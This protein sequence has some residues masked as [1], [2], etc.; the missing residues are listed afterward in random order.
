MIASFRVGRVSVFFAAFAAALSS[1]SALAQS[2][3]IPGI[4]PDSV[5][6]VAGPGF[7]AG[8]LH[9]KLLGDNYRDLWTTPIRV[10]VLHL[11]KF[12]GGVVPT[13]VGGGKQT[14]SLRLVT[15]DSVEFV[16]REVLKSGVNLTDNFRG[17]L[18]WWIFRD[19]GSASHPAA[20]VAAV[21]MMDLARVLH[22]TATLVV[23]PDDPLLGE[24]RKEFA[25]AFGSLE[26]YPSVPKA[27]PGFAGAVE[28]LD[29]QELL[30][31][32]NKHPAN[33]VD[34]RTM[35]RARLIDLLVGDNDRH[36]DQWKWARL[37]KDG[38]LEPVARDRD[39]VFLSYEGLVLSVARRLSPALVEFR[40]S[41]PDPSALF[42]NATN[43]DRR[44][45]GGFDRSV[46]ESTANEL[47]REI[48]DSIID[49]TIAAMPAEYRAGSADIAAKLQ[50]R[51]DHLCEAAMR[52]Y[53][54][55]FSV[56]DV[57]GTD[58]ADRAEITRL[59]D[60]SVDVTL[61]SADEAPWFRRHYDPTDTREIR[62]YLHD[63]DDSALLTGTA[64]R[65]IA[66]RVIGGNGA[67]SLVDRSTVGGARNVAHLYDRG[68]VNDVKYAPDSVQEGKGYADS[69]NSYYNRRPWVRSHSRLV[70]PQ[71]DYG[72]SM[73]PVVGLKSGHGL[74]LVPKIGIARYVYGF[75]TAPYSSVAQADIA[76][77]TATRGVRIGAYY[78]KRFKSSDLHLPTAA[79]MSQI[80]M[81]Q[82]RGLGNQTE[83]SD[84]SFFDLKQT[85]WQIFP[86]A[87]YT[88]APG[89]D[90]ALGPVI[91]YTTTDSTANRFVTETRPYGFRQFGQAG[92]RLDFHFDTRILPDTMKPRAVLDFSGSAYPGI[93]DAAS[94]YQAVEGFA[95]GY[96][97]IRLPNRPVVAL[98][99]GGKKLFGNFPYFDAAFIGGGKSLR[100]EHRQRYAGDGSVYGS[101]ELRVPIA[102]FSLILPLDVGALAFADAAR[103]YVDGD[104]PGRWHTAAGGGFWV[105]AVNPGTSLNVLFTNRSNRRVMVSLGFAY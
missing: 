67:N 83:E 31:A 72:S 60:G 63:G 66:M 44:I 40:S 69:L 10:P 55:L 73:K 4:G 23:M 29:A 11:K 7:A 75:R 78:D 12:A 98:R 92:A 33:R 57:H 13:K 89:G 39:K 86:A 51:R 15:A 82:F 2:P 90:V 103:V 62:I 16:F 58:A 37:A 17:S 1:D 54:E 65:S 61:A 32:I 96:I 24:F 105:G 30:N 88:F 42:E 97:T 43:F 64:E 81:I 47:E 93:W 79:Q 50:A 5:T 48:T 25:G 45:L 91:R 56:A 36:A 20:T 9:R 85:Q 38:I 102:R 87:G 71:R 19:A 59:P 22:P 99:A 80:E 6:I 104:S 70:P 18:L 46:W 100:T 49:L 101:S 74:G 27:A 53:G 41:Y 3:A 35:L 21:P 77:S 14:R 94:A 52:Y 95:L 28:I 26:Q 34:A 76:M 84:Q 8:A 68:T